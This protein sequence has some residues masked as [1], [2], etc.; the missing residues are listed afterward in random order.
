MF[1]SD[2]EFF[3]YL[4]SFNLKC[5]SPQPLTL[6]V[7]CLRLYSNGGFYIGILYR[8]ANKLCLRMSIHYYKFR[9]D[10][11]ELLYGVEIIDYLRGKIS[12]R[13]LVILAPFLI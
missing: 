12:D 8:E 6:Y 3:N 7:E 11:V 13:D 10:G 9:M 2:F 4:R 5:V 1:K